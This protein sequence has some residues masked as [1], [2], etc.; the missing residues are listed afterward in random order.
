EEFSAALAGAHE[1]IRFKERARPQ[2]MNMTPADVA[3]S[4][5]DLVD[6]V[7]RGSITGDVAGWIA[8]IFHEALR[9][10]YWGWF[11][12]DMAFVHPWGFDVASIAAPVHVWQGAHDRM[13]PFGHGE[14]LAAHLGNAKPHLFPGEGHFTLLV[15]RF[16]QVIDEL[17]RGAG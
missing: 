11:D 13:V 7:D 14:W 1:L 9:T 8:A 16:P 17:I 4:F 5:G 6:D 10:S 2:F 15:D 3:G 12:D